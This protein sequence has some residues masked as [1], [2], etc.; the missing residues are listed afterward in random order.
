L[1]PFAP[2]ISDFTQHY[3]KSSSEHTLLHNLGINHVDNEVS[4]IV[5]EQQED[6]GKENKKLTI[7]SPFLFF[8]E[9]E[10]HSFFPTQQDIGFMF[11]NFEHSIQFTS[12]NFPP[13]KFSA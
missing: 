12:L 8:H 11:M 4:E 1:H 2:Y 3:I 7:E 9:N 5:Q 6:S 10:Q 13:P